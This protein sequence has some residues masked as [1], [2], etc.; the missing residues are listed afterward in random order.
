ME[1]KEEIIT[2]LEAVIRHGAGGSSNL[3][4]ELM[5]MNHVTIARALVYIL[6]NVDVISV[7]KNTESSSSDDNFGMIDLSEK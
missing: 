6:K 7:A 2:E 1:T 5:F 3:D 4:H